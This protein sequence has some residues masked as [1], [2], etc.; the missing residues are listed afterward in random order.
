MSKWKPE[1]SGILQ[2][3]Y[4]DAYCL[5]LSLMLYIV[6]NPMSAHSASLWITC[7]PLTGHWVMASAHTHSWLVW[8]LWEQ[9]WAT[10][11]KSIFGEEVTHQKDIEASLGLEWLE[12]LCLLLLTWRTVCAYNIK[13]RVVLLEKCRGTVV[14]LF[15]LYNLTLTDHMRD[16]W[17]LQK[18]HIHYVTVKLEFV[19][20]PDI[21]VGLGIQ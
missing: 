2:G 12:D 8:I 17:M 20:P 11:I 4:W 13:A 16:W 19:W 10:E 9:N 5:I 18:R 21:S 3:P 7:H 6:R 14:V 1:T 15:N